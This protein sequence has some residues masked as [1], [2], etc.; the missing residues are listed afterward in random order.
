MNEEDILK[1]ILVNQQMLR[2]ILIM[3]SPSTLEGI[4]LAYQC[5]NE[6]EDF[7]NKQKN[8]CV[9]IKF[10]TPAEEDYNRLAKAINGFGDF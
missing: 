2:T 7:L 1:E 4:S 6:V 3:L 8:E 5:R 9:D 10:D